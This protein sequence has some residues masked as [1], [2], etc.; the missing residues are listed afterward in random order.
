MS[1]MAELHSAR[2]TIRGIGDNGPPGPT[3]LERAED[4]QAALAKFLDETPVITEG[5]HLVEAKRLVEH[6]R[7]ACAE[8][9]DE[10]I[11]LVD[12]LNTKVAEI[13]RT[14]KAVHNTDKKKP[15]TLDK[16]LAELTARLTVYG[17]NEEKERAFRAEVARVFAANAAAEAAAAEAAAQQAKSDAVVGVIDTGVGEAIQAAAR[18][19]ADAQRAEREAARA[20]AQTTFRIGN[21]AGKALGMHTVE[22]LHLDSY[23]RALKAMGPSDGVKEAILTAA[24]AY[25]K[26]HGCLPD[27]VSA[28]QE[29]KF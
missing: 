17:Q 4:A 20:D 28:T 8:L 6:V 1:V 11:T 29:R 2:E 26:Q 10:R 22:T 7:G 12:P 19:S 3:P 21:G 24:R 23:S 16:T 13:N 15:G 14:Y 27:G 9:E 18:A 25:R 5:P